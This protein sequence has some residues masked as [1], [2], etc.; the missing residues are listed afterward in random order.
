MDGELT[1]LYFLQGYYDYEFNKI[2]DRQD[3]QY[4]VLY[5]GYRVTMFVGIKENRVKYLNG[6][7]DTFYSL[8]KKHQFIG[9]L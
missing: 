2:Y 7:E 3:L 9:K 6:T 4:V 5:Y 8:G 1:E